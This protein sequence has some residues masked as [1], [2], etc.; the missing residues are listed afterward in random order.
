[1]KQEN[2]CPACGYDPGRD[3]KRYPALARIRAER[4]PSGGS[5]LEQVARLEAQIVGLEARVAELERRLQGGCEKPEPPP[6][7]CHLAADGGGWTLNL[8]GPVS[9][10]PALVIPGE[11][12]GRPVRRLA[13]AFLSGAAMRR[14]ELPEELTE[15]GR[16]A[17]ADCAAL[18]TV[19][20]RRNLKE[21]GA[22][23]FSGCI[24]LRQIALPGTVARIG[25]GAFAGCTAL[26][27]VQFPRRSGLRRIEQKAFAGCTALR[28]LRIPTGVEEIAPS[29]FAD[30][31]NLARLSLPGSCRQM[32]LQLPSGCRVTY[33]GN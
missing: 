2:V 5:A 29:A 16:R 14:V 32:L 15:I 3:A 21:I 8:T 1:M 33:R 10:G 13:D 25:K 22:F 6:L 20:F 11:V 24:S 19:Q 4:V 30:C 17:F 31:V 12:E 9:G 28:E 26:E 27:T 23:A 18:E 7:T